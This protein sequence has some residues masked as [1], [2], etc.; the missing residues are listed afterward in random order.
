MSGKGAG[1][2]SHLGGRGADKS[3]HLGDDCVS[4]EGEEAVGGASVFLET[5]ISLSV[6]C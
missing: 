6:H 1:A 2:L 3:V 5:V 4:V